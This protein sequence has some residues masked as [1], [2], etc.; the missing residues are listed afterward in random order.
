[1]RL[2]A[3]VVCLFVSTAGGAAE[4]DNNFEKLKERMPYPPFARM[5]KISGNV[6]FE[7]R[8]AEDGKVGI[9]V[10]NGLR[11]LTETTSK[12]IQDNWPSNEIGAWTVT[13]HFSLTLPKQ[14]EGNKVMRFLRRASV[15]FWVLISGN[16]FTKKLNQNRNVQEI[17]VF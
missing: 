3:L 13:V 6:T 8:A 10:L 5:A 7:V 4:Q 15:T 2:A 14:T 9:A 16:F 12:I 11:L 1:M 17:R